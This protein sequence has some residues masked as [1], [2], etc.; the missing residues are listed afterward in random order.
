[1]LFIAFS[2]FSQDCNIG[3]SDGNDPNYEGGNI[4]PD[5]FVRGKFYAFASSCAAFL[6]YDWQWYRC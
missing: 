6:E 5:Y 4:L 3:N 1:M 2:A